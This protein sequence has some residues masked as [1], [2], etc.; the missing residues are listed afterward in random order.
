MNVLFVGATMAP[1]VK[2]GGLADVMESLPLALTR[3]G[4]NVS[5][6]IPYYDVIQKVQGMKHVKKDRITFVFNNKKHNATVYTFSTGAD[7]PKILL[8]KDPH[9]FKGGT[10]YPGGTV[11]GTIIKKEN[12]RFSFFAL[13]AVFYIAKHGKTFDAIHVHDWHAATVPYLLKTLVKNP[14]KTILTIHNLAFQGVFPKK[15]VE[16][17]IGLRVPGT[18]KS[19]NFMKLG[20]EHADMITT[21]SPTYAQEILT[22]KYGERLETSLKKRKKDLVGILN[23]INLDRFNPAK[24]K[25]IFTNYTKSSAIKG[26]AYN[27]KKLLSKLK[28]RDNNRPLFGM[29]SRLFKQK[30]LSIVNPSLPAVLKRGGLAVILGSG[31]PRYEKELIAL[32]KKYPK[33]LSATIGFDVTLAQQIYAA[34]DFFLIPS[35]YEPCG[36]G[37]MIAMRYGTLPIARLT[38][39]L[40]DTVRGSGTDANGITFQP[41]TRS[42]MAQAF[43]KAFTLYNK[44]TDFNKRVYNA[45]NANFSWDTSAQ[46][47]KR[48]YTLK[49]K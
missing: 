1:L 23:G 20:I 40:K 34:S 41:F 25:S 39:G 36:L 35:L 3:L 45:L 44:K 30:G 28:L 43:Q 19:V 9:F 6:L 37:Q 24:D 42:A 4:L 32:M 7:K 11:A 49:G 16:A 5:V 38:G 48:L 27:R 18:T 31:D 8:L 2:V 47:Y 13:A 15:N 17:L 14:P 22:R 29:V 26:K 21:V 46:K 33:S 10:I 12:R